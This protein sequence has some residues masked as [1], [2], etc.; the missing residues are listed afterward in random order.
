MKQSADDDY[1]FGLF[2]SIQSKS[3]LV[4]YFTDLAVVVAAASAVV[5]GAVV[6][7]G[8]IIICQMFKVHINLLQ[9]L[10][11]VLNKYV[12]DRFLF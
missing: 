6:F 12:I 9:D 4:F 5:V 1:F 3:V 2:V 10:Q 8:M 11:E 7:L